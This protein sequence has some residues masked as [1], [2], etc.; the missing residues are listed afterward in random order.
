LC[1]RKPSRF[2]ASDSIRLALR[3]SGGDPALLPEADSADLQQ[4]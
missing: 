3:A 1:S 4:S 2:A